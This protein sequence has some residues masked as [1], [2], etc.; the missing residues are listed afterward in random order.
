MNFYTKS[1]LKKERCFF[2]LKNGIMIYIV[3]KTSMFN[4]II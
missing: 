3:I 4:K 2:S 1:R